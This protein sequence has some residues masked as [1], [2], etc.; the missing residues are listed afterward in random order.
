[1]L[2]GLIRT[3]TIRSSLKWS[4]K[5]LKAYAHARDSGYGCDRSKCKQL[6]ITAC[7]KEPSFDSCYLKRI[8]V[9]LDYG[10]SGFSWWRRQN[11]ELT[12]GMGL[13]SEGSPLSWEETKKYADYVRKHGIIQF[14]NQ[15]RKLKDRK[16][17]I[18]YWGDEVGMRH[19]VLY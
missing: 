9:C 12:V 10:G 5:S 7:W 3:N 15:Y 18:L 1:M 19:C 4:R 2:V 11:W 8:V 13:L 16:K 17:D 6:C 14:L